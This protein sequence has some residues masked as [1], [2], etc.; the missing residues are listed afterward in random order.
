M[1][2]VS[3]LRIKFFV[4]LIIGL[5]LSLIWQNAKKNDYIPCA[6]NC[7][8]AFGVLKYPQDYKLYGFKYGLLEDQA[9]AKEPNRTPYLYTHNL[10]LPG[11]MYV[12]IDSI[13][14]KELWMKQLVTLF[15][16]GLGLFYLFLA[17][18]YLGQSQLL[19]FVTLCLFCLD[20]EYVFNFAM[21]PL[22]A[23]HWLALFG[24][25]Y[26]VGKLII[27]PANQR[28]K[29]LIG[30]FILNI[31]AF[32]LG[33]DFFVICAVISM[34]L[35]LVKARRP[36]FGRRNI[37]FV[38]LFFCSLC[39]PFILRQLQVAYVLGPA[40]LIKDITYSI[41]TKIP[42][43]RYF[44]SMLSNQE[45]ADY[46][47]SIGIYRPHTTGSIPVLDFIKHVLLLFRYTLLPMIGIFTLLLTFCATIITTGIS[48]ISLC[49]GWANKFKGKS[50]KVYWE[51]IVSS[52]HL[53][54][55]IV[56]GSVL[57]IL[58]FPQHNVQI[59]VKH[60]VPL[61]AASFYI[62]KAVVITAVIYYLA[63]KSASKLRVK[64]I[65]AIMAL[66][67]IVSDHLIVQY[68]NI[69]E[70]QPYDMTWISAIQ[71][72]KNATF[73]TSWASIAVSVFTNKDVVEL[74]PHQQEGLLERLHNKRRPFEK[75]ED[76]T[77]PIRSPNE[78]NV[79]LLRPD[80][81]LYFSTDN[82]SPFDHP[83][84]S[85]RLD[86]LSSFIID[87]ISTYQ[88]KEKFSLSINWV[89]PNIVSPGKDVL[90][91]GNIS[92]LSSRKAFP[93]QLNLISPHYN[94]PYE[95]FCNCQKSNYVGRVKVPL[96][97][98]YGKYELSIQSPTGA[99][100]VPKMH[101]LV[102]T[103]GDSS[104]T[105]MNIRLP[106]PTVESLMKANPWIPIAA[107][108]NGWVLFDLRP[109]YN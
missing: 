79:S 97:T 106:M 37:H 27:E 72:R 48:I 45:I 2:T 34:T 84:P 86:Y 6:E 95:I 71:Q 96:N 26:H 91:G 69:R 31:L 66:I 20:Y 107:Q 90:F 40:F 61:L 23:W 15:I 55:I 94:F 68:Y 89:N 21:N 32:G 5:S 74:S 13:G 77:L 16:H 49:P 53:V 38:F 78:R 17:V 28:V 39:L 108:G 33:Y 51:K 4:L 30:M 7:G 47:L 19:G 98:P 60:L 9:T 46:F 59:Y 22:R 80:Y 57:G 67:F 75:I 24:L 105:V 100:I 12:L 65:A 64:Y 10:N 83:V 63:T 56:L 104:H 58:I 73:V 52:S 87:L 81:W 3:A 44:F 103:V 99:Q 88:S 92:N 29:N 1:L 11:I 35:I 70:K 8:E 93:K 42:L 36:L 109:F 43:L 62:I 102:F 25:L 50:P 18:S 41:A 54:V 101:N 82:M 14:L 85:C 76:Y